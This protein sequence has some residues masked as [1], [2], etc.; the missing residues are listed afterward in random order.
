MLIWGFFLV[1]EWQYI[2]PELQFEN[3]VMQVKSDEWVDVNMNG[4]GRYKLSLFG[5]LGTI[6][7]RGRT[8]RTAHMHAKL[9]A[10]S[11][12]GHTST[13]HLNLQMHLGKFR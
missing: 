6:F 11:L 8:S 2:I 5:P 4:R 12:P 1:M 13:L 3:N 7:Q 10:S 9:P